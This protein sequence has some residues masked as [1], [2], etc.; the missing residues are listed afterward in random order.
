MWATLVSVKKN[1][2]HIFQ[3]LHTKRTWSAFANTLSGNLFR[4]IQNLIQNCVEISL[5]S[6]SSLKNNFFDSFL[7]LFEKFFWILGCFFRVISR[8][9]VWGPSIKAWFIHLMSTIWIKLLLGFNSLIW[10]LKPY[11]EQIPTQ[12][13][14]ITKKWDHFC[15]FHFR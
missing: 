15:A 12:Q 4:W 11:E 5:I 13:F 3:K 1:Q 8:T 10:R 2:N 14:Y 6:H 9:Q 7:A